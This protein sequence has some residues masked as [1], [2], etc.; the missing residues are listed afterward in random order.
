MLYIINYDI[1]H[2]QGQYVIIEVTYSCAILRTQHTEQLDVRVHFV[3]NNVTTKKFS[4]VKLK[5]FQ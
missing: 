4:K 3:R 1:F 5:I 2:F